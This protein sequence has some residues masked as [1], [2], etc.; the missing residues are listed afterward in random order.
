M[1]YAYTILYVEDVEKTISFYE[2]AFGFQKKFISPESD[3]GELISGET[4]IAFASNV[5][6]DSNFK[7]G[8][9]KLSINEKSNGIE[10]AFT[11]E[12]IEED[13]NKAINVGAVKYESIKEKPWGQKVGYLRD[14]NGFLIEICTPI[15]N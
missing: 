15:K 5:L 8:F 10:M 9:K 1:K 12:N 7:N 3:Y 13:F 6:G 11:S 4:T 2:N 14:I